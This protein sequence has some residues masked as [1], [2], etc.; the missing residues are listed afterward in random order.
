MPQ[1]TLDAVRTPAN[2][3]I[4]ALKKPLSKAAVEAAF[5]SATEK[6]SGRRLGK[7]IRVKRTAIGKDFWA[8]FICFPLTR[9]VPF[10]IGTDLEERTYGFLLLLEVEVNGAWFVGIFKHGTA[11]LTD[12]LEARAKPLPRGKFTRAF[13][14][15]A[16]VRKLSVKKMAASKHELHAAIYEAPDLQA[17]LPILAT[18]RCAIRSLRFQDSSIGSIAITVNTSRVQ[19]SGGRCPV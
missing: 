7:A 6:A 5:E 3:Q 9:P 1:L 10:L 12:W 11:S 18:A 16:A 17:S 4:F 8:S 2:G 15:K 13:S 14:G 19:R